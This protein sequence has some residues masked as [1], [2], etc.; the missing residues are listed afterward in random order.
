M[1]NLESIIIDI[2][3][4]ICPLKKKFENYDDLIPSSEI[5]SGMKRY[6]SAGFTIILYTSRNMKTYGGNIGLINKNTATNLIKWLEKWN[7]PYDQIIF[8]KPWPGN[9]GF[10]VDDRTIR[11]REFLEKSMDEIQ[12]LLELD[13][14]K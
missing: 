10:Y 13:R 9:N 11:P 4:T 3:G 1:T 5:I 8:G 6:Q 14:I 12:I 7:I 2:D